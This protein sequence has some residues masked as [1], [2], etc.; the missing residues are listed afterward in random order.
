MRIIKFI[1]S[2][3]KKGELLKYILWKFGIQQFFRHQIF[4]NPIRYIKFIYYSYFL[5]KS[6]FEGENYLN[7]KF[8]YLKNKK[9]DIFMH[10]E[11]LY[12]YTLECNSVFET[13]VRG[14][15]SSWA[16]LKGLSDSSNIPKKL[17]LN[18]IQECDIDNLLRVAENL[19]I[20]TKWKWENNLNI[21][22]DSNY[23]LIFI[24][25][26][27]VYGQLKRELIK[28]SEICNK[29]IILHDTTIDGADGEIVRRGM[30]AKKYSKQLNIPE[31]ELKTGLTKA[32]D[33]FLKN[34]QNWSLIE[35]FEHNNGLTI[36]KKIN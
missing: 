34:N 28:F 16:F 36:L 20:E 13:G 6:N 11:T 31:I 17:F 24:D 19:G 4:S 3:I 30:D 18:D 9:S 32:I 15:V 33:E 12:K 26:L 22:F 7:L 14:V 25:T 2:K 21:V 29:Y 23:D 27:H 35:H 1:S 8:N 10:L 5:R